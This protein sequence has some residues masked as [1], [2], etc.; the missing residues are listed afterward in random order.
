MD[1]RGQAAGADPQTLT[2]PAARDQHPAV[3]ALPADVTTLF[4]VDFPPVRHLRLGSVLVKRHCL[5]RLDGQRAS[6]ADPQAEACAV[7]QLFAHHTCLAVHQLDRPL[8]AR[9]HARAT[10]IAQLLVNTHNL[11][12]RHA[13]S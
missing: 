8:S 11:S 5:S 7:T 9:R 6:G 2:I 10:A 4:D 13:S 3:F 1:Q 12:N